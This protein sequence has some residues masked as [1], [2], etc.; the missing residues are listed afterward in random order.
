MGESGEVDL[1]A[2]A[3]AVGAI[4]QVWFVLGFGGFGSSVKFF[5]EFELQ[6]AEIV[7][8]GDSDELSG[9]A[10]GGEAKF[11]PV[12]IGAGVDG[13]AGWNDGKGLVFGGS[14]S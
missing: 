9:F 13:E 7:V 12:L 14:S 4:D 10:G 1:F 2:V 6:V 8:E 11:K 5:K 3:C